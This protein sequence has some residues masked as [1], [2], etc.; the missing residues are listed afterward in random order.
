MDTNYSINTLLQIVLIIIALLILAAVVVRLVIQRNAARLK[1]AVSAMRHA[2]TAKAESRCSDTP[3]AVLNSL[4]NAIIYCN[5]NGIIEFFN[6][7]ANRLYAGRMILGDSIYN[8]LLLK[9]PSPDEIFTKKLVDYIDE[10]DFSEM[11][12]S[13]YSGVHTFSYSVC[14]VGDKIAISITDISSSNIIEDKLS[15]QYIQT[16]TLIDSSPSALEIYSYDG[17]LVYIN[18]SFVEMYGVDT[19]RNHLRRSQKICDCPAFNEAFREK[20]QKADSGE[21]NIIIDFDNPLVKEYYSSKL[22]GVRYFNVKFRKVY[23][24]KNSKPN[25]IVYSSDISEQEK[26]KKIQA[27]SI[28]V[29][30]KIHA[31]N[32]VRFFRIFVDE[33]SVEVYNEG[34]IRTRLNYEE[35]FSMF[36]PPDVVTFK[37]AIQKII[38]HRIDQTSI[39]VRSNSQSVDGGLNYWNVRIQ[40]VTEDGAVP[41]IEGIANRVTYR[42]LYRKLKEKRGNAAEIRSMNYVAQFDYNV[43]TGIVSL[44]GSSR[45]FLLDDYLK[46]VNPMDLKNN[47]DFLS[48]IKLGKRMSGALSYRIKANN[49]WHS[50]QLSVSP[51]H[52]DADGNV[53][54]FEGAVTSNL[55]WDKLLNSIEGSNNLLISIINN[56]PCMISIKDPDDDFRYLVANNNFC[57]TMDVDQDLMLRHTDYEIFGHNEQTERLYNYDCQTLSKGSQSFDLDFYRNGLKYALHIRKVLF[58]SDKQRYIITSCLNLTKLKSTIDQLEEAKNNAERS[59]KLKSAF[60]ANMS[61]EIRTPLNAICGFSELLIKTDNE[62]K[63]ASYSKL[64]NTNT[65]Y[66]LKLI[67]DILDI[68]KVEAG[69]VSFNYI[70]FDIAKLFNDIYANY[71]KRVPQN[72]SF[73]IDNPY[74]CCI[75]SSDIKRVKQII[76]NYLSNSFKYTEKG[77]VRMG[78][79]FKDNGIYMYVEDSGCG[80]SEQDCPRIFGRFEKLN[81][82]IQGTGLGLALCKAIAESAGGYVGFKSTLGQGS[83]F[84]SWIPCETEIMDAPPLSFESSVNTISHERKVNSKRILIAEDDDSNFS[85]LFVMLKDYYKVDRAITGDDAVSMVKR[86]DYGMI[87]MDIKMPSLSGLDATKAIRKLGVDAP[88]VAITAYAYQTDKEQAISAGCDEFVPKP[89]DMQKLKYMMEKYGFYFS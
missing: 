65:D 67:G 49:K 29:I 59:D 4:P 1:A 23:N 39:V 40:A 46:N 33:Q 3:Y 45:K 51:K 41:Y 76:T 88:I 44:Q 79:K 37:D 26:H 68:S 24:N 66:L 9:F 58:V 77:F 47:M 16:R 64:I 54:V 43:G 52:A 55:N 80:I 56:T 63:K 10:V 70:K 60:L 50:M 53:L 87:F 73:S 71:G 6:D 82:Y 14:L 42:H 62:G 75:V 83:K 35:Y 12:N 25:I 27:Y 18:S 2:N 15:S 7:A 78:Y 69:Y 21:V 61:H 89:V 31:L 81:P 8:Y 11:D 30:K 85:L 19:S 57:A 86:N 36:L 72:V 34:G 32:V 74:P 48:G 5:G 38:D 84:W 20:I 22:S 13:A 17:S 28:G